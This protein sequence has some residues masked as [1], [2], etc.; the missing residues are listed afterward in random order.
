MRRIY[1][2]VMRDDITRN[3]QMFFLSGPRQVGKTTIARSIADVYLTWDKSEDRRLILNGESA[4]AG[5]IGLTDLKDSPVIVAFD[6]IHKYS[7]WK[8]FIKGFFDS[9]NEQSNIILTGS[10]R[11]NIFK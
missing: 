3:R 1:T 5:E 11:L 10:A 9:Y 4:V 7:K 6:E 2:E 8:N